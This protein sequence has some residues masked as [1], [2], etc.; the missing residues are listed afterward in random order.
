MA[1]NPQNLTPFQK[2]KPKTGGR[3]K[4]T[5]N[6][7]TELRNAIDVMKDLGLDPT[8]EL[9]KLYDK[10]LDPDLKYK[11]LAELHKYK[12]SYKQKTDIN[13]TGG[14]DGIII[15]EWKEPSPGGSTSNPEADPGRP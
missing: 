7:L 6:K 12:E 10:T 14:F 4:G 9:V 5:R 8:T 15:K 1:Q 2:G 3:K 13:L 11:I